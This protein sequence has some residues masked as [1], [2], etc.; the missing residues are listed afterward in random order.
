MKI[1]SA[2]AACMLALLSAHTAH[3]Q[4]E[5][6]SSPYVIAQTVRL[7]S[8]VLQEE[9]V[10]NIML[11]E[12]YADQPQQT[13]PVIYLLDGG[14]H[15][16]FTHIAGAVQYASF[17]W[18]QRLPP[19]ILVGI[20]NTDRKRDMTFKASPNFVWPKWLHAYSDAYKFAGGSEN[21][22]R[23]LEQEVIPYVQAHYRTNQDKTLIGQSLA[24]LLATEVL[25]KK[26]QLFNNYV[27]MSPSL[28]WDN[29]SLLKAAP[30]YLKNLPGSVKKVYLAV[31]Q[32]GPV[33]L[34]DV[35]ALS[36]QIKHYQP[37]SL[38][39]RFEYLPQED[40]G[41][42]LHPAT[43]NAFRYFYPQLKTAK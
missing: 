16:D 29:Q 23:Y 6:S 33:M 7:P 4:Q 11:P 20:A 12:G 39:Y 24:G 5:A 22:M 27:I 9:R 1:I 42:I 35:K 31:G 13:Y 10:L 26:P 8:Q 2:F 37:K 41:S 40:H 30:T 17:S 38:Y 15:E 14:Q 28:W 18:V 34:A 32:E 3:A 43:L 25:L 21:F 36:S 19:S